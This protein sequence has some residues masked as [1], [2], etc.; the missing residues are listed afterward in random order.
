MPPDQHRVRTMVPQPHHH[1]SPMNSAHDDDRPGVGRQ[2]G[3]QCQAFALIQFQGPKVAL[4]DAKEVGL[5]GHRGPQPLLARGLQDDL[6]ALA[7][8]V[9]DELI[10]SLGGQS[11]PEHLLDEE[12]RTSTVRGR[13]TYLLLRYHDVL[14][15]AWQA[16][17]HGQVEVAQGA[18]EEPGLGEN[19]KGGRSPPD[20]VRYQTTG[21]MGAQRPLGRGG[22]L[23]LGDDGESA[24]GQQ[25]M[26]ERWSLIPRGPFAV[27]A[28]RYQFLSVPDQLHERIAHGINPIFRPRTGK[29]KS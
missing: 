18:V 5:A 26:G 1:R 13:R 11:L 4:V 29:R 28:I 21:G 27:I 15:Q 14:H 3:Q 9:V 22:Q 20:V 10:P 7:V 19:G 2:H 24:M 17:S 8:G 16:A 12:D 23:D 25:R 6:Q